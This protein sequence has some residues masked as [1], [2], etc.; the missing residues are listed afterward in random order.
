[1][2]LHPGADLICGSRTWSFPSFPLCVN[3]NLWQ[4][5]VA[6]LLPTAL[7]QTLSD[8]H[9]LKWNVLSS[10]PEH[11]ILGYCLVCLI[12]WD[13]P[14]FL[15]HSLW[16]GSWLNSNLPALRHTR[17]LL[18]TRVKSYPREEY[19]WRNGGGNSSLEPSRFT[20]WSE[21][22]RMWGSRNSKC[23]SHNY[24]FTHDM[25]IYE[26]IHM[27]L[28]HRKIVLRYKTWNKN[29]WVLPNSNLKSSEN[30]YA[31]SQNLVL[32]FPGNYLYHE[33][34][35]SWITK[36]VKKMLNQVPWFLEEL[37][38][39]LFA[40]HSSWGSVLHGDSDPRPTCRIP[41]FC[42]HTLSCIWYKA[43]L[44]AQ[45]SSIRIRNFT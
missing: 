36:P 8:S 35:L 40:A 5:L 9:T 6:P 37:Y 41:L 20:V 1:M 13:Q 42:Y 2:Q 34:E 12:V 11:N 38:L 45:L 28:K 7:E 27:F 15:N 18:K 10:H 44:R 19:Q 23:S 26:C 33:I 16:L 29:A 30:H 43:Y 31:T 3:I 14:V 25:Q 39:L 22:W 21:E 32:S 24:I 4:H 17:P